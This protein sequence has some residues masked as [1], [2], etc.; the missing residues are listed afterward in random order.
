MISAP[1]PSAVGGDEQRREAE[2]RVGAARRP[3]TPEWLIERGLDRSNIVA[4]RTGDC[5]D[6]GKRS[7]PATRAQAVEALRHQV[8]ACTKCRPDTALGIEV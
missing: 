4:V 5:W 3:P 8:P 7:R 6:A 1:L 2:R